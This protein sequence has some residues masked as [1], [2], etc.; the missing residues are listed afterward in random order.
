LSRVTVLRGR[1]A[2][3]AA[4]IAVVL[5]GSVLEQLVAEVVPEI[6]PLG[7]L[8]AFLGSAVAQTG[9]AVALG[10]A[11]RSRPRVCDHFDRGVSKVLVSSAG[12][13]R[14]SVANQ[15]GR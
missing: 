11:P 15:L 12:F 13:H 10:R 5:P 7:L 2:S 14:A 4:D 6:A 3:G 9:D 8:V 1:G